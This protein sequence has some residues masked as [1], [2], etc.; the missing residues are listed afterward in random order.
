MRDLRGKALIIGSGLA[1]LFAFVAAAPQT[2]WQGTIVKDGDVTVVK[3]PKEPLHRT[4]VLELKED[5]SIGGAQAQGYDVFSQISDVVVDEAGSIYV[6]DGRSSQ[7][8]V[9][10]ASGKYLRTIGR[11][12]QGP[13][14]LEFPMT[15]SLVRSKGELAVHQM[16]PRMAFYKPD[17][18]F[19]R[20]VF[21]RGRDVVFGRADS[22]GYIYRTEVVADSDGLRL[23]VRKFGPDGAALAELSQAPAPFATKGPGKVRI[24]TPRELMPDIYF[25]L[26][27]ADNVVYGYSQAYDLT[28]FRGADAKPFK[29]I[30]R[31]YDF[32]EVSPEEK[33]EWNKQIPPGSGIEIDFPKYHP[34]YDRFFAGDLGHLFVRTWEKT[35]DGK[36]IHDI[37]DAEGR[38]IGRVPLKG[39]GLEVLK[40]KYYA[41]EE[42]EDG[43]QYVRRYAVNWLVK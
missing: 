24:T 40:G 38:L 42:D 29:K 32:V 2:A 9:F 26:D 36:R 31:S 18:T 23:V 27:R 37:F 33:K 10:D 4:P 1:I 19:L 8:K 14:E 28:I 17:G 20:E 16:S 7:V 43:Y 15:L 25:Q 6:L 11:P 5:L 35:P 39:V 30:T 41:L 34:A 22:R 12:G 3:N 21:F 13:G